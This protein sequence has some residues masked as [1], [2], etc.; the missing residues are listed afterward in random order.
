MRHDETP[1]SSPCPLL[2]ENEKEDRKIYVMCAVLFL[3][4]RW[5]WRA[6][7]GLLSPFSVSFWSTI[8][9]RFWALEKSS[10]SAQKRRLKDG[11]LTK[12]RNKC[13]FWFGVLFFSF[14]S[15]I[16][17]RGWKRKTIIYHRIFHPYL[18]ALSLHAQET[19]WNFLLM[20]IVMIYQKRQTP[21]IVGSKTTSVTEGK[22]LKV[23]KFPP[24]TLTLFS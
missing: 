10:E 2:S 7:S 21:E 17:L 22:S 11:F 19:W 23:I 1:P 12:I 8:T 15:C 24:F 14:L 5:V 18:I 13:G 4:A 3:L 9:K 6:N 16:L 20:F